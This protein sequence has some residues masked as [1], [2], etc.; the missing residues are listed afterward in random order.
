MLGKEFELAPAAGLAGLTPDVAATALQ[1]AARRRIVW[2]DADAGLDAD[3]D[4]DDVIGQRQCAFMHDKLRE[5]LLGRL[6]DDERRDL[7]LQAALRVEVADPDRVFDLAYHF[8]AAG[9]PERALAYALRAGVLA[10]GQHSLEIA[11]AHFRIAERA[12]TDADPEIRAQVAESLGDILALQGHYEDA[13]Q[14]LELARSLIRG[15]VPRAAVEAKLGDVAFRQGDQRS[16]RI[17]L[18]GALRLLDRWA[19]RRLAGFLVGLLWETLVQTGHTLFPTVCRWRRRSLDGADDVLLAIRVYSRLA[20]VYWYNSGR[21]PCGWAHL[22]EMNLAE[23]YP[24]SAELAQAYS[25]HAPV[26][27]MIPWFR[28]GISYAR[29]SLAIRHELDDVWGQGQSLHFYGLVLYAA[30][31]YRGCIERCKEA[32]VLLERTGDRWEVNTA[33]W[34]IAFAH[35]RLGELREAV[36]VARNLHFAAL[37]IGDRAAA[38]ASLSAWSRASDGQVPAELIRAQ[39]SVDTADAQTATE[40]HLAEAVRLLGSGGIDAAIDELEEAARLVHRSGLRQEYVATVAP[41]LA[42]ARRMAAEAAPPHRSG[43][44]RQIL[45][46]ANDA[47]EEAVRV[48]ETYKNNLP[49]ALRE[50]GLVMALYGH[51]RSARRLLTRSLKVAESQGARYEAAMTRSALAKVGH[52]LGWGDATVADLE[53]AEAEVAALLAPPPEAFDPSTTDLSLADRF[54]GLQ[55]VG[56][57]VASATSVEAVWAAVGE[58][59]LTL[60][61]GERC[62]VVDVDERGGLSM[63][64]GGRMEEIST[65]VVRRALSARAPVLAGELSGS[66]VTDSLVLSELRSV[67]CAPVMVDDRPVACFYV[68]HAQIGGLFS[69]EEVKLAEFMAT[70]AGA[71]LEHLAGIETR[72]RSLAQNSTDVITI[73]DAGGTIVYQSSSVERVFGVRPDELVGRPLSDWI[74]PSD[75]DSVLPALGPVGG[76]TSVRPLIE[77]RLRRGDGSWPH[78]ETALNDLFGDPSVNGLV[79]NSRDVSER[80]ALEAELRA[81]ALR[82]DLTGLANRALFSD[83]VTH[84]LTRAKRR[85]GRTRS[86]TSTSTASRGSTT[87]SGTPPA[88]SS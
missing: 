4:A 25:E 50:R 26:T 57:T 87:P 88:T 64:S 81:R 28:R 30:S 69:H 85:P 2:T 66:Q 74:H 59:A 62:R 37:D 68:T 20:F 13:I 10:R 70:V 38:G 3:A 67:L 43:A 58:A 54:D 77:C 71:A 47:A 16:A 76:G 33:T 86:S 34:H 56:R 17:H 45:R 61:R 14:E 82:D 5:A 42:T 1:E 39:L 7:H 8:D 15:K 27:T 73:V 6:D 31:R 55:T 24:P 19:P 72:F 36:E 48:A 21:I 52:A 12:A 46:K 53:A 51:G 9:R 83:R 49:H 11:E 44:R 35:Y 22:R 63:A 41:W 75:L 23:R 80:H 79:L 78:V 18:E 84:A 65:T 40:L 32:V 60:L 29:K